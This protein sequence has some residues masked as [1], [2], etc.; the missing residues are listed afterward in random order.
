MIRPYT[1]S[2][3]EELISIFKLN[4][5]QYFDPKEV[6]DFKKYLHQYGHTYLTIEYKNK[7]VGGV[8]YYIKESD[9]SGRITWIFFHPDY[10]GLGLGR[11][12]VEYAITQLK[13][14]STLKKLVVTTSQL[15]YRFFEKFD[16]RL[17][18]IENDYWG[19][20]LDLYLMEREL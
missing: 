7:I 15:A 8:G 1:L 6:D 12:A 14:D 3:N 19:K 17:I 13:S 5:P 10:S 11:K 18:Q 16:Y 9:H 4:T 20:G 2:D